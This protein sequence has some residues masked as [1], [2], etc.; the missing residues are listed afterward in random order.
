[1]SKKILFVC[2]GNTCRSVMAEELLK[3]TLAAMG[4]EDV[5]VLSAGVTALLG[6]RPSPEAVQIM[7]GE[8]LDVSGHSAAALTRERIEEV[9]L[10]LTM[11]SSQKEKII[12]F[13]PQAKEKTFLL[14]EFAG[15]EGSEKSLG[16]P[17]PIGKPLED[18][19]A[20]ANQI[21]EALK[22]V[23]KRI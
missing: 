15:E 7:T 20:C 21:K 4:R 14:K 23:A 1:M 19:Q 6:A 16:I 2:A 22:K 10:I 9:D 12:A 8:G 18:Y 5:E 3:K 11:D 13:A 17:D